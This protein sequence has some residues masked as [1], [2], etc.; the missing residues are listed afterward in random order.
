MLKAKLETYVG[1]RVTVTL[2]DNSTY[3][4]RLR[5]TGTEELR[6]ENITLFFTKNYYFIEMDY[7]ISPCFRC[8]HVTKL[9]ELENKTIY[10]RM[11][12]LQAER[13]AWQKEV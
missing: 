2:F 1:K 12:E 4:G 9:K 8:S 11:R 7:N 3:T 13:Y 6:E 10:E 5:K